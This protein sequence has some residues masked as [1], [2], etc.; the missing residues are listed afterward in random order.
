MT[1]DGRF[2]RTAS[3]IKSKVTCFFFCVLG[4]LGQS[5]D[6]RY[7]L[8][9]AYQKFHVEFSRHLFCAMVLVFLQIRKVYEFYLESFIEKINKYKI[10]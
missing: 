2:R 7:W 4:S 3:W 5:Y 1:F 6:R 9:Y 8:A 10:E